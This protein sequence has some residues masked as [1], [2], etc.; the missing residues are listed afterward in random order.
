MTDARL[1]K[2]SWWCLMQRSNIQW[3]NY[4]KS[5]NKYYLYSF[6]CVIHR[7]LNDIC[8]RFGRRCQFRLHK[9]VS[10]LH[11]IWRR[12]WHSIAKR[13]HIKLR[14]R[15]IQNAAKVWNH[16][17]NISFSQEVRPLKISKKKKHSNFQRN[18]NVYLLRLGYMF[19]S[20]FGP[21]SSYC[22]KCLNKQRIFVIIFCFGG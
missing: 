1:F 6:F 2:T 14:R 9:V 8:R 5:S 12:N 19:R 16:E 4:K 7:R 15:W 20:L 18:T 3:R 11:R 13:G 17:K 21:S 10:C 22:M